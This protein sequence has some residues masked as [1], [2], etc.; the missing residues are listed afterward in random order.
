MVTKNESVKTIP[1]SEK[2]TKPI[3]ILLLIAIVLS[4][5]RN[6]KHNEYIVSFG[7]MKPHN[8]LA[9]RELES[10]FTN[11]ND[12]V[13]K[14]YYGE[15]MDFNS[16]YVEGDSLFV[17]YEYVIVSDKTEKLAVVLTYGHST[18]T[19]CYNCNSERIKEY[20][21]IREKA[22]KKNI[23][24]TVKALEDLYNE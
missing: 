13:I 14:A 20:Q 9:L 7:G 19:V 11:P 1:F 17:Y 18:E 16:N 3:L 22:D 5:N 8:E 10:N 24:E 23:D 6:Q 4:C 12:F 21:E 15:D 2:I